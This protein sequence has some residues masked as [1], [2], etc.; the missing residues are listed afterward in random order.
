MNHDF[1]GCWAVCAAGLDGASGAGAG[2]DGVGCAAGTFCAGWGA[3]ALGVVVAALGFVVAAFEGNVPGAGP[4]SYP[5]EQPAAT[6][7]V[8]AK[9]TRKI[10]RFILTS[11]P[12]LLPGIVPHNARASGPEN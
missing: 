6:M 3:A 12:P 5:P 2:A 11:S 10:G 1:A 4:G 8:H 7:A 9:R